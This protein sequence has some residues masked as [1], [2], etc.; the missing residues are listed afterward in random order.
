MVHDGGFASEHPVVAVRAFDP[1]ACLVAGDDL[2]P[3][4][5]GQHG[6]STLIGRLCYERLTVGSMAAIQRARAMFSAPLAR[7]MLSTELRSLAM[8]PGLIRMRLA[9][10]A[11]VTSRT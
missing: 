4:Q 1:H 9:S 8:M 6:C 7:A 3:A 11:R 2:G 10:S 5:G